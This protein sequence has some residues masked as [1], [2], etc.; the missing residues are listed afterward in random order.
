MSS[1]FCELCKKD[2][3][4]ENS[5]VCPELFLCD[6]CGRKNPDVVACYPAFQEPQY[7]EHEKLRAIR[8]EKQA[9]QNFL[10]WLLDAHF[11]HVEG[12][13]E[14]VKTDVQLML[15]IF[16]YAAKDVEEDDEGMVNVNE[17]CRLSLSYMIVPTNE[18]IR[19]GSSEREREDLMAA[20]FNIDLKKLEQ[21]KREML[22]E[23]RKGQ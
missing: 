6:D 11:I 1:P 22:E 7:P 23:I 13:R 20:F 9:V 16:G 15:D 2:M 8:E 14:L 10:D 21:E 12:K 5:K 3:T 4:P 19:V 18:L 17:D